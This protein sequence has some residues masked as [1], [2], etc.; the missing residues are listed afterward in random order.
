ML[1]ETGRSGATGA[2]PPRDGEGG[3]R[4]SEAKAWWVGSVK[5]QHIL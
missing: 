5:E 3:P 2:I 1:G 4:R